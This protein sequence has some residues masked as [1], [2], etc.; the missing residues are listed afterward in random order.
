MVQLSIVGHQLR[1]VPRRSPP[2]FRTKKLALVGNTESKIYTPWAD[3]TWTI[4]AHPCSSKYCERQPDWYFDLHGPQNFRVGKGWSINYLQWLQSLT[5]P[6]FMQREEPDI[7]MSVKFPK[8]RILAEFRAY[9]TNH[10]AWMI[11]L[12]MTE[13]VTHIGLFG[14]EYK[15]QFERGQ[16]RGS[17]EFWL[18][19]FEGRGGHVI[20]PPGCSLLNDPPELY[21]YE[22]HDSNGKL[23]PS[24]LPKKP[25]PEVV[26]ATSKVELT[27]VDENTTEGRI[28]LAKLPDGVEVA[29]ERSGHKIHK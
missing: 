24:Y 19:M 21:G 23:L 1:R 17:A 8:Q 11:A 9:F 2:F 5:V 27:I 14:C 12:A 15:H 4:A 7:P 10:V 16:Q 22:S 25:K 18:G 3:P 29:W 20:L 26:K 13:G 6:V 28:P